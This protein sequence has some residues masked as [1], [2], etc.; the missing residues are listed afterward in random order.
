MSTTPAITYNQM[1]RSIAIGFDLTLTDEEIEWILWERTAYPMGGPE[2]T[3]RQITHFF[4]C[5]R[6][7]Y[8]VCARCGR[9]SPV[10]GVMQ[11]EPCQREMD[12]DDAH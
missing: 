3:A 9:P 2:L 11:C 4:R 8:D 6:A 7:G 10:D 12:M 5:H 1:V